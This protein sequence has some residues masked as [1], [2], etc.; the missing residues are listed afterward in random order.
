MYEMDRFTIEKVGIPGVAL[1]ENAGRAVV[2][3]MVDDLNKKQKIAV[4]VGTGNNGGDGFVIA[5]NL[6][7]K[8]FQ[9]DTLLIPPREKM[10]GDALVH[11]NIFE[12]AGYEL[13]PF[14]NVEDLERYDVLIDA[15]LGIGI[16]GSLRSPYKEIIAK[17]NELD[18]LKI[19]VD[20]PSGLAA[21]EGQSCDLAFQ[22]DKTI[23]LQNPKVSAFTYPARHYYGEL[24]VADIGIPPKANQLVDTKRMIWDEAE[25]KKNIPL[26]SPSSHKSSYGKGLIIGGSKEMTGAP[27][28]TAK[29]AH[30]S[31]AGLITVAIP[32]SI[33]KTV[34]SQLVE[35]TFSPWTENN[36]S[37][38]GEINTDLSKF[39][40]IAV[41]PG[42][43][44]QPGGM[45]IL[46]ELLRHFSGPLIIDA[47]GLYY[48]SKQKE[49]LLN[50]KAPV[51]ITPHAGEMA[52]LI[53]K[54]VEEIEQN[55]FQFSLQ[56]AKEY[57]VYV[58]LKGPYTIVTTPEGNQFINTTGNA[59]LAKGGSGDVLTGMV[60][61]FV[62]QQRDI[63]AAI[64]NAVYF[65]G[66]AADELTLTEHS[67]IDVTATDIIEALPRTFRTVF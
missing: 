22:A 7:S 29:A 66:K 27:I 35:P 40:A 61:A 57:G 24:K 14:A 15:M 5:R 43:G 3:H 55:R 19:A 20:I 54:T 49:L 56:F 13:Y 11:M 62:M 51:I 34:T 41:G 4:L 44:R 18:C 10:K 26:R 46:A 16:K 12:A 39:D 36:G 9:V 38:A 64:S 45:K 2:N 30:R 47:D 52:R 8:G 28:M 67:M 42:M 50:K 58:V 1:M 25:V 63:Q 32:K 6:L 59:S 33:Y 53:G 60:L 17:C 65:H 23:T 21:D 31:G 37:F 48:L